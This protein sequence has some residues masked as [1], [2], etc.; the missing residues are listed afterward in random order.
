MHGGTSTG[1]PS[2][3]ANGRY[4][5]GMASKEISMERRTIKSILSMAKMTLNDL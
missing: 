4:V 3:A 5:H 1:A 2:G